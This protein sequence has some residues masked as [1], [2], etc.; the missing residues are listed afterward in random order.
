MTN[1]KLK[2]IIIF[3]VTLCALG[4]I[5]LITIYNF[6]ELPCVIKKLTNLSCPGCGI[7]RMIKYA[8]SLDFKNAFLSNPVIFIALP[9]IVF[10]YI[11]N[12]I[13]YYKNGNLESKLNKIF[14]SGFLGVLIIYTILRNIINI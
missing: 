7:S 11:Y 10:I 9:F 8:I 1:I 2:N 5:F 13:L 4:M 14:L 12:N 6:Y 3:N